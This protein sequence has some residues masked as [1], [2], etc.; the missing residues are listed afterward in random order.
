MRRLARFFLCLASAVWL[1]APSAAQTVNIHYKVTDFQTIISDIS[2]VET[3]PIPTNGTHG[4]AVLHQI[5]PKLTRA[6]TSSLTNGEF[7]LSNCIPGVVYRSLISA[8]GGVQPYSVLVPTNVPDGST[9][10]ASSNLVSGISETAD[11]M[12]AY[13]QAQS[14]AKFLLKS[15]G[16]GSNETFIGPL[17]LPPGGS[18][19]DVWTQTNADGSGEWRTPT[20]GDG[21]G[22]ATNAFKTQVSGT[23]LV[24]TTN[25]ATFVYTLALNA[26]LQ[27]WAL[28]DTNAFKNLFDTNGAAANYAKAAT[29]GFPWL[30]IGTSNQFVQMSAPNGGN[31]YDDMR[32]ASNTF[33]NHV[34]GI[35]Y[36]NTNAA[37][38]WTA[39]GIGLGSNVWG[40]IINFPGGIEKIGNP[41]WQDLPAST[42]HNQ[43]FYFGFGPALSALESAWPSG[44]NGGAYQP[45]VQILNANPFGGGAAINVRSAFTNSAHGIFVG[46]DSN[47]IPHYVSQYGFQMLELSDAYGARSNGILTALGRECQQAPSHTLLSSDK[48][49]DFY[50]SL[51]GSRS[52][53]V[54]NGQI[55]LFAINSSNVNIGAGN[56]IAGF[57]LQIPNVWMTGNPNWRW[58]LGVNEGT[59]TVFTTNAVLLTSNILANAT[60]KGAYI[61]GRDFGH[62]SL[63]NVNGDAAFALEPTIYANYGAW[64]FDNAGSARMGFVM[65]SGDYPHLGHASGTPFIISQYSQTDLH[66]VTA[67]NPFKTNEFTINADSTVTLGKGMTSLTVTNQGDGVN[68]NLVGTSK[69][70]DQFPITIGSGL[71]YNAG[72]RTLSAPTGGSGTVASVDVAEQG[73]SSSGAV[74][75]SGTVTL[76]QNADKNHLGFSETNINVLGF[77]G[78]AWQ[79]FTNANGLNVSNRS[80]GTNFTFMNDGSFHLGT[81]IAALVS[82]IPPILGSPTSSFAKF[83]ASGNVI[84][85]NDATGLTNLS[86]PHYTNYFAATNI[87]LPADGNDWRVTIT[88]GPTI[89][90]SFAGNNIGAL[91]L[92]VKTNVTVKWP[93]SLTFLGYS[94]SVSTNGVIDFQP[95]GGTNEVLTGQN[96]L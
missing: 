12:V 28:W 15:G 94:N 62:G 13:S 58:V 19:G 25:G 65:T 51:N 54:L 34:L 79:M 67:S 36:G 3:F 40:G 75:S 11:G 56:V 66:N 6:N 71:T 83:D 70:G 30:N 2:Q 88:N 18:V 49:L 50:I 89:F 85:T 31:E 91:T 96:E 42:Y 39:N 32:A 84:G 82:Q 16:V 27:G 1:A 81:N 86:A 52:G 87:V 74:T 93:P 63:F 26:A 20:V 59:G 4:D 73:Y 64:T 23:G 48:D 80:S 14:N 95:F 17:K 5:L 76:T 24:L 57:P 41:Y 46:N 43:G 33:P 29:N 90:L 78:N 7:T 77:T 9:I 38:M 10:E 47:G 61:F 8:R 21:G 53:D 22:S 44:T 37:W 72:T 69:N 68:T 35:S 92:R 55:P 45:Y 60:N